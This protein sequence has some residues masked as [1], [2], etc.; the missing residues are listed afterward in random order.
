LARFTHQELKRDGIQNPALTK[1]KKYFL[2]VIEAFDLTL[3]NRKE[4][5]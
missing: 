2:T 3:K 4:L 5:V 1:R